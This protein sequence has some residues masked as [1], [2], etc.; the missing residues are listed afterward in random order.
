MM[1][2]L[3]T[4]GAGFF[5]GILKVCLLALGYSCVSV[6]LEVDK[7]RHHHLTSV[8]A[9]I[10]NRSAI[11]PLFKAHKFDCRFHC[12]AI[13]AHDAKARAFQYYRDHRREIEAR[14]DVSAHQRPARMGV[15]RLLKWIS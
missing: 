10:R 9:D 4:G 1:S 5:G 13:L 6:D 11:E 14:T 12:A 2:A 15:I 8:Q 7:K 3:I